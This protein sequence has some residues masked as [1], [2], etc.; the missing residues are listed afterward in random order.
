MPP[1]QKYQLQPQTPEPVRK[2]TF[3]LET[4]QL[5][6]KLSNTQNLL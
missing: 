4:E 2:Y 5:Y 3:C 1:H 6:A